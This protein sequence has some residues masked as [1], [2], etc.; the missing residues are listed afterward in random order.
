MIKYFNK[1]KRFI[2]ARIVLY[3]EFDKY[4]FILDKKITRLYQ[5]LK[6]IKFLFRILKNNAEIC[7]SII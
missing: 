7:Y 4:L 1:N 2:I 5:I 6:H 3:V